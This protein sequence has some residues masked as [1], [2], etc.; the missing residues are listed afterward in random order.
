VA[1]TTVILIK[2]NALDLSAIDSY[3][4]DLLEKEGIPKSSVTVLPLLYNTPKKVIAKT[5]KAYLD[6]LLSKIP[7]TVT[8]LII[9][10][11][12]YFKFISKLQKITSVYGAV[13]P[14]GYDGY[15]KFNCVFVPNYKSLFKQPD[16]DNLIQIGLKA[17][18]G[19]ASKVRINYA[20]YAF[21]HGSERELLDALYVHPEL[22]VDVET[23]GLTLDD[24]IISIAFA[25]NKHEGIA[26]DISIT[27]MH[28]VKEFL[29]SYKGKMIFHNGL[30]DIKLMVRR[31]WME[32]AKDMVGMM[33]G[34]Q[35]FKDTDDTMLMAYLAKNSTTQV[36]LGLKDLALDYVGNYAIDIEDAS[37]YP[38]AELLE[39]NLID[40]LGT[41]YVYEK[42]R[43]ELTSEPYL[44]IFQPSIY[45]ILKMM[46]TGLPVDSSRVKEVHTI[47]SAKEKVLRDQ[48]RQNTCVIEFNDQ[49][50]ADTCKKANEKLKVLVKTVADFEDV[51]FNPGSHVQLANL[52]FK[53]H[54]LPVLDTT[55]TG[56]PATGADTLADLCNHTKDQDILDLLK[57][58]ID[59][60]DVT[61]IN[62]T[63]IKA[64]LR[65]EDL[66][67]GSLKLGGTQSGR[68]ASHD[69][70][71]TNIPSHGANGKLVKSCVVAEDG[72]LFGGADFNALE[73]RG[74][75]ILTQD[76]NR[77]KVYTDGYDGHSMRTH[78]YFSEK[79][80]DIVEALVKAET[81]TN[82]WINDAGE[83]CCD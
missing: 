34:I 29:E 26:I 19:T 63:F 11:S 32:H 27:G 4:L 68:L 81:A 67:H 74:G 1:I 18:A 58:V 12:P 8:N 6:K 14:G 23:T 60:A 80:P 66:L 52:L 21:K 38:K 35:F 39:Y 49:L 24:Y 3:Y 20:G 61:K 75:A 37:K 16:N 48:I 72:W 56:A 15:E 7:D 33:E 47:L 36:S 42:Y 10:D 13:V 59:L 70:N 71:L 83:Y 76:P 41:F 45:P 69:P 30:F 54:D 62:G 31:W 78:K 17:I 25:W 65:E 44:Q 51:E 77:I 28:Y 22:T 40:A 55:K 79:M 73:E 46:L 5:A 64:F 9:A 2:E 50:R 57:F 53:I 82:F 43:E